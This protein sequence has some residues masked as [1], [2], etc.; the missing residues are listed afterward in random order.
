MLKTDHRHT[1]AH[2]FKH[3]EVKFVERR[4]DRKDVDFSLSEGGAELAV[5][6]GNNGTREAGIMADHSQG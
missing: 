6:S 2:R 5:V 4:S 1:H 3:G